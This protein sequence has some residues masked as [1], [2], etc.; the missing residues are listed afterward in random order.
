[1]YPIELTAQLTL[2]GSDLLTHDTCYPRCRLPLLSDEGTA[3]PR[4]CPAEMELENL[5]NVEGTTCSKEPDTSPGDG[6]S[7]LYKAPKYMGRG[8]DPMTCSKTR[9]LTK[10]KQCEMGKESIAHGEV[11]LKGM[12]PN[13]QHFHEEGVGIN[14]LFDDKG[15]EG[16]HSAALFS[17]AGKPCP[18]VTVAVSMLE[19]GET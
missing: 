4:R 13:V 3:T 15:P 18:Q 12:S 6:G 5:P 17:R 10:E 9:R 7:P 19:P 11:T 2:P 16:T 8:N 14:S 1:M